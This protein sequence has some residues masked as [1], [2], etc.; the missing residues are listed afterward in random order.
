MSMVSEKPKIEATSRYSVTQAAKLLG[1]HRNTIRKYCN[2]G[3]L[4]YTFRIGKKKLIRGK[5]LI[6]LWNFA[7][8][9]G[10]ER[11]NIR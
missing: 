9:T 11:I 1:L 4:N 10:Y 8:T 5:E 7:N 6:E 3:I 2:A